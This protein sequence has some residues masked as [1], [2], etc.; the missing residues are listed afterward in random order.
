MGSLAVQ[1]CDIFPL[2]L[3]DSKW[4]VIDRQQPVSQLMST[5]SPESALFSTAFWNI[6][7]AA[8]PLNTLQLLSPTAGGTLM[9]Q[10]FVQWGTCSWHV[11]KQLKDDIANV[12][13]LQSNCLPW[14]LL[15]TQRQSTWCWTC[16][17]LWSSPRFHPFVKSLSQT[18]SENVWEL[19][20]VVKFCQMQ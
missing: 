12:T 19:C 2:Y 17:W 7:R 1:W 20:M 14:P 10:S 11:W 15:W 9:Q 13:F 8:I 18:M 4:V 6:T 5:H 3:Q 16:C